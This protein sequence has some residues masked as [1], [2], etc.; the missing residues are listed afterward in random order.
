M[1]D[2]MRI[3]APGGRVVVAMSGGVDSAVAAALMKARGVEVV[4]VTLQLYNHGDAAGRKGTCCAGRDIDDARRAADRLSIPHYVLDYERRFS[5]AVIGDF[6]ANYRRGETPIPCVHCNQKLKF[7]DLLATAR[8]LGAERLATGHYVRRLD[9]LYGPELHRAADRRRDQSYFLFSTPREAL[10][11]LE[12]PLGGLHKDETR[13]L[14]AKFGLALADKPDSQDIC[15]VPGGDY[16]RTISRFDPVAGEPGEI[17][18]LSGRVVGQ[19]QGVIGYTVG[20]RRGLGGGGAEPRY[21]IRIDAA[22]R[23]VVVGPKSALFSRCVRLRD[24]NWLGREGAPERPLAVEVKLRSHQAAV[25]AEVRSLAGA[26]A[27][28]ALAD[29]QAAVAPGQACVFYEGERLLGGGWIASA[30]LA[31]DPVAA[32]AA[33]G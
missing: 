10:A 7:G 19:H 27:E 3:V 2:E 20:Q 30:V 33:A 24:V 16:V 13:K 25:A 15:F 5:E 23:R 29:P 8:E 11:R 18:D 26:A 22:S 32:Q 17:V 14:A 4:G 1:K 12:F 28:V 6:V 9:G 21:V 31:A